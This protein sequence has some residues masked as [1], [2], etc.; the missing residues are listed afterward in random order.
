MSDIAYTIEFS[1]NTLIESQGQYTKVLEMMQ[2]ESFKKTWMIRSNVIL[3]TDIGTSEMILH[4]YDDGN[5]YIFEYKTPAPIHNIDMQYL[6]EWLQAN[7][8]RLPRPHADLVRDDLSFWKRYWETGLVD[9][10]YL[11]HKFGKRTVNYSDNY[12]EEEGEE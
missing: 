6:V 5:V 11:E 8:W 3:N 2:Q 9:S 12:T 4:F 10:N 7:G 1:D